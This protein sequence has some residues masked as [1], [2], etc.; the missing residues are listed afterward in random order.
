MGNDIYGMNTV[1]IIDRAPGV[2]QEDD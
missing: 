2:L 1:L